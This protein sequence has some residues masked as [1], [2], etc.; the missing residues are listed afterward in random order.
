MAK[1]LVVDD[2]RQV[3][4]VYSRHLGF[5]GHQVV[6]ADG[7]ATAK[8]LLDAGE[9][10]VVVTDLHMEH[11]ESG[12]HV[13]E[14]VKR[15][16]YPKDRAAVIILTAYGT[17]PNLARALELG[18]HSY[19]PK[20]IPGVDEI[21][22]LTSKVREATTQLARQGII[23][24][25]RNVLTGFGAVELF[26]DEARL[27]AK[28]R[29]FLN[30][31]KKSVAAAQQLCRLT[32]VQ[33]RTAALHVV[34]LPP[35]VVCDQVASLCD[36]MAE[37]RGVQIAA[38]AAADLPPVAADQAMLIRILINLVANAIDAS[39]RGM[40]V[41]LRVSQEDDAMR[42]RVE[43]TGT[44]MT[45]DV[46]ARLWDAGFTTK[47]GCPGALGGSGIGLHTAREMA[48]QMEG[49]LDARSE[50]GRGSVFALRLPTAQQ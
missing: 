5:E 22:L 38:H 33:L 31:T 42:F 26:P 43:D 36:G 24:D 41:K 23:H 37:Q 29:A 30:R 46:L 8:E 45:E 48:R 17:M 18:A 40:T 2:D 50:P 7:E 28:Q 32:E 15:S 13:L 3:C 10:D 44:G 34:S 35:A 12:L 20:N 19:V 4:E 27:S 25:M 6:T 16:P 14:H 21:S 9:F 11:A 47:A 39:A 1:V 49:D